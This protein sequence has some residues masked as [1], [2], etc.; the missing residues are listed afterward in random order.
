M[1]ILDTGQCVPESLATL[2]AQQRQLLAGHR[3]A[4]MFPIGT[5]ELPLPD[6]IARHVNA[7][8]VFHFWPGR[9]S[10]SEIDTLSQDGHENE[11]LLLGPY[12]KPEIAWR[13]ING[14]HPICICER[15]ADGVE[16]RTAAGTADT[17]PEQIAYFEATKDDPTNVVEVSELLPVLL[18]RIAS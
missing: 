10:G 3:P 9:L 18:N 1:R 2:Q 15:N 17:L 4:Q 8:G 12:S 16:L 14:E 6:G 11:I 5:D 13:V 7:R